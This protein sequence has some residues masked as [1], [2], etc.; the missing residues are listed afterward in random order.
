MA[1]EIAREMLS[2]VE[3]GSAMEAVLLDIVQQDDE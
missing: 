3:H 2:V 1:K